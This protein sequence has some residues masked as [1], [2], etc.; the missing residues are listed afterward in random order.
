MIG[1]TDRDEAIRAQARHI[2]AALNPDERRLLEL[3]D[4]ARRGR[5]KLTIEELA[6]IA[7]GEVDDAHRALARLTLH[8]QLLT[9]FEDF[10]PEG[11]RYALTSL[12][13]RVLAELQEPAHV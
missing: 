6:A 1:P 7:V 11:H 10:A 13:R 4:R 9:D 5:T 8:P 2:G 3:V 12:G